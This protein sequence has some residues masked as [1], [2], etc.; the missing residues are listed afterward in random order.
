MQTSEN[1]T[2][3]TMEELM[4]QLGNSTPVTPTRG[5]LIKGTVFRIDPKLG[6]WI[7][8]GGKCDALVP[9]D[10]IGDANLTAGQSGTFFV[11]NTPDDDDITS[12][13]KQWTG[14]VFSAKRAQSW[15]AMLQSQESGAT[16]TV[17]VSRVKRYGQH[18]PNAGSIA[19]VE[20]YANGLPGFVPYSMLAVG[21]KSIDGLVGGELQVKVAQVN[22]DDRKLVFS[23][24]AFVTEQ[25]AA[26]QLRRDEL[27]AS[28]KPG[29][30]RDGKVVRLVEYGAFVDV[31]EGLHGLVHRSQLS[32]DTK[33]PV[34]SLIQVG[35]QVPVKVI[36]VETIEGKRKLALSVKQLK[37]GSFLKSVSIG[38]MLTGTVSRITAFGCFVEL[39]AEH[40]VDGLI[41]KSQYS[42]AVRNGRKELTPGESLRVKVIELDPQTSRVGLSIKEVVQPRA[43]EAECTEAPV[44][45]DSPSA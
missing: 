19:G 22:P 26:T 40:G 44:T 14:P 1:T 9:H 6:A 12:S 3:M 7:D 42:S 20:V 10:E 31:G 18:G 24:R 23:H 16:V 34:T 37:Q 21:G 13:S 43:T 4:S 11:L 15:N 30:I 39:S 35:D 36:S 45:D 8:F 25:A 5:T 41:H 2:P 32:N 29:D 17:N 28:L 38:D 27:F 33:A